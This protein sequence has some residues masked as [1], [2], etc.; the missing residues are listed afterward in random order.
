MVRPNGK[1]RALIFDG[2]FN[3]LRSYKVVRKRLKNQNLLSYV[4]FTFSIFNRL[5]NIHIYH[6]YWTGMLIK[7]NV[8]LQDFHDFDCLDNSFGE[9]AR[10][11]LYDDYKRCVE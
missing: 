6:R 3:W 8:T 5:Y 9:I 10:F 7:Y 1:E 2:Y 11:I 4:Y